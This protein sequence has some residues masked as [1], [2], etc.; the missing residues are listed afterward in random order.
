[1]AQVRAGLDAMADNALLADVVTEPV[2][3]DLAP[4]EALVAAVDTDAAPVPG[5]RGLVSA[6]PDAEAVLLAGRRVAA[7]A[8]FFREEAA[9]VDQAASYLTHPQLELPDDGR[10]GLLRDEARKL[11]RDVLRLAAEDRV[12]ELLDL[13]REFRQ[14]YVAT[15]RH[16]H[17]RF[18]AG[19]A[20]A[21]VAAVRSTPAYQALA[22]LA[23]I[24]AL[25]VGDD[26]VKV[27]RI[28]AAAAP[29]PCDRRIDLELSWK[30]RCGCGFA[31]G[32]VP[33]PFDAEAI[34]AIAD[35]GVREHL[36][37]LHRPEPR[38]RLEQALDHLADL[39][40]E[41]LA[42]DLR[43]LLALVADPATADPLVVAHLLAGPLGAVVDDV[44][45]GGHLVVRRDLARLRDDLAGRRFP[46]RRL[47]EL[48]ATWVDPDGSLPAGG[49]VEVVDTAVATP[50]GAPVGGAIGAALSPGAGGGSGSGSGSG[51]GATAQF[52][53]R[54][55][56]RL[57][58]LLPVERAGECFWLAAWWAAQA[59]EAEPPGWLPGALLSERAVL[60]AAAE[61]AIGDLGARA[62][63]TELD[64]RIGPESLLGDQVGAALR[65]SV[66][67]AA[68]VADVLAGE[69]LLRHPLR[70]AAA[71]LARRVAGDWSLSERLPDLDDGKLAAAHALV[72][73]SEL[74]PLGL[75]LRAAHHLG[76]LERRL[77]SS[78]CRDLVEEIYPS[79]WAPVPVLLS[80][81][82][83]ALIG[84]SLLPAE[85]LEAVRLAAARTL[86]A[87]DT[88]F[89]RHA[90][91]GFPGCLHIW[92]VGAAVV[93]PL[94]HVHGRVA[95]L[96]VDAM[97]VDVWSR[98]RP[99][100]V[101][102]LPGRPLREA[103]AVVPEPTRTRESIAALYLGRPVAAGSGPDE[104]ADLGPPFAHLGFEAAALVGV[105]R[106][107]SAAALR[108]LWATGSHGDAAGP[109]RIAVAVA[110]GVDEALHRSSAD[111]ASLVEEA[112]A[113]LERRVVPTL[114]ALPADVPLVVLADH[115]FRENRSWGRGSA[116]RYGHGG[117]SL[118]ESVIPVAT[119]GVVSG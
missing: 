86:G 13:E 5:L 49:F 96:V 112:V 51:S 54:R 18:Y 100:L 113:G 43:A 24:G 58:A 38:A 53:S 59:H 21:Q 81:A 22:A 9:K 26:R 92:E 108:D 109:T 66:R 61:A 35:R 57:A 98:F 73:E 41:E 102:A 44:L 1:M 87:A 12:R 31:I 14:A 42:A 67:P 17:E 78:S 19:P 68:E 55:F 103:W 71:D 74:A 27:D 20:A 89:G 32:Q 45:T 82:E 47:L 79:C 114:H 11:I 75:L 28:L 56:P 115:G 3:A 118:E 6:V 72:G 119:F 39:G 107:G 34:A 8:R 116:S 23:G 46:K 36:C 25:A 91:T 62:E 110:T 83:L 95:V 4:M 15:Y 60:A 97:R 84:P 48:V 10:L 101:E 99:S 29:S 117:L 104:P 69:R 16:E 80:R 52:L 2:R 76:E 77:P 70:L 37:E 50:A 33:P 85:A 64:A 40:R 88:A 111:V 106:D 105:D 94:L 63:L 30:P 93:A 7:V 90:D 65:L